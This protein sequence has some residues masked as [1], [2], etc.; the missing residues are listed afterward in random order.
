[1]Q[2]HQRALNS[3]NGSASVSARSS[4]YNV[5]G[6]EYDSYGN[7][8]KESHYGT[9]S[10]QDLVTKITYDS[11]YRVFPIQRRNERATSFVETAKYHGVNGPWSINSSNATWGT[12]AEVCQVND[13]CTRQKYD[14]FGRP[15]HRWDNVAEGS[16]W[17]SDQNANVRWS[18]INPSSSRKT[19]VVTE[20]HAPRWK[21]NFTRTQYNGLGQVVVQQGPWQDWTHNI[22]GQNPGIGGSEVA[23]FFQYDSLGNA[24][25]QSVPLKKTRSAWQT[26]TTS[27]GSTDHTL[28]SFDIYGRPL[29]VTAP[30]G[31]V[32]EYN[33]VARSTS[34]TQ[35]KGNGP[36]KVVSWTQ[37]DGLGHLKYV[38]NY[39]PNGSSWTQ[40]AQVTLTHNVLGNLT[41]VQ[42]VEGGSSTFAYDIGGR[43]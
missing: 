16:S 32:S 35:Y 3:C 19:Y 38:R 6:Y 9:S 23:T 2:R 12:M 14:A 5:R 29:K 21:G 36:K 15:V 17:A 1:M 37:T 20:W 28:S 31:E 24:I 11:T 25:R 13:V 10:S 40:D 30:N 26:V 18:Y 33:H 22:D 34:I 43:R 41:N 27:W 42:H 4:A 39:R 7:M 8:T